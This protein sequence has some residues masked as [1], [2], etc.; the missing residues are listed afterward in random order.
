MKE[1][2]RILSSLSRSF[3]GKILGV[4]HPI[5]DSTYKLTANQHKLRISRI[6]LTIDLAS[7]YTISGSIDPTSRFTIN[8]IN[9]H[10]LWES[11]IPQQFIWLQD[12]W[13]TL[14]TKTN[15][16]NVF[17]PDSHTIRGTP[18]G[19]HIPQFV[20]GETCLTLGFC[21]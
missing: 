12:W 1:F 16:F 7:K 11:P 15:I 17:C 9:Q 4:P 2:F 3:W 13:L 20:L 19:S 6:H 8:S 10:N 5:I 18:Q 14:Q 21:V